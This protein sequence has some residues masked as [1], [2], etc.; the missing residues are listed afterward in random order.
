MSLIGSNNMMHAKENNKTKPYHVHT[1]I[2]YFF[3]GVRT[4]N[5]KLKIKSK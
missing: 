1:T 4:L 5:L 2:M 3:P